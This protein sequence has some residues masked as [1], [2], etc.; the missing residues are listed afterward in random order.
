MLTPS[1]V[2]PAP[3]T[4]GPFDNVQV[5]TILFTLVEPHAGPGGGLQPVVRARPLLRRLPD[6]PQLVRRW[7][8]GRHPRPQGAPLPRRHRRSSPTST[9]ARTSP[10]TGSRRGWTPRPSP[11]AASRCAGCTTTT[12]C[13]TGATT[14]TPSCTWPAGRSDRDA[15]GVPPALALDHPF[16]GLTVV[17]V[18][19][20]EDADLDNRAFSGW[21][22]DECLPAVDRRLAHRAR[23]GGHADRPA[24]GCAGDAAAEPGEERRTLLLCFLDED[25]RL[26]WQT[27]HDLVGRRRRR[28]Q[29]LGRLRRPLHPHHPR[30]RHLH[31]PA[32]EPDSGSPASLSVSEPNASGADRR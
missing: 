17:M 18:D 19:R 5:G 1:S 13:S 2:T 12:A 10:P 22:R 25:P 24:Q 15:D 23:A 11:G 31:R 29:R 30:H 16:A 26:R 8:L 21:L 32:L 4:P 14:S 20:N 28:R 6:R 9:P 7:P 27:L 3:V